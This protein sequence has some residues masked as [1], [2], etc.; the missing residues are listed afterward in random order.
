MHLYDHFQIEALCE[1]IECSIDTHCCVRL[2]P[3]MIL[4]QEH[5]SCNVEAIRGH[6]NRPDLRAHQDQ[7]IGKVSSIVDVLL[8]KRRSFGCIEQELMLVVYLV[9]DW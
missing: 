4:R 9:E 1:D 5:V 3:G 6:Q 2:S 7:A 8:L